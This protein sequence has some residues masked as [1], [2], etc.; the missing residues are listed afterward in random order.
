MKA[1]THDSVVGDA[2][3]EVYEL[4]AEK[5]AAKSRG[6]L[7]PHEVAFSPAPPHT[8]AD[9]SFRCFE[10]ARHWKT[11]PQEIAAAL[12]EDLEDDELVARAVPAGPYLNLELARGPVTRK[13]LRSVRAEGGDYGRSEKLA[14]ERVMMEYVSPNTN[15]PLHLGHLRNA[16]LGR[17][18]A[19]LIAAQGAEVIKT[20]IVNDRGIHIAKS[21]LAYERFAE[22]ETP[23][24]AGVKGDH[25]VGSLYVR[26]EKELQA[27][28]K[29][30]LAE[31]GID[32]KTLDDK[33]KKDVDER[34]NE[35]SKL[36]GGARD[37]LRRWEAGDE[38][39]RALWRRMNGWVY[40]GFAETYKLLGVDFDKHYYESEIF[41]GGRDII[42]DALERG[43]FKKAENGAVIAPLSE[44]G[45]LQDKVV[46][47]ADG[48]GLYI[49][50]DVNLATIKFKEFN[51]TRSLYCIGSEQDFYMKQLF[52]TLKLLG[53]PWADGLHHL[54]YGMVYLPE[55]K[56][57]S[58]EGKVVD[59]DDL[60]AGMAQLA[61]EAIRERDPDVPEGELERRAHA[62]GLAAMTFHFLLVGKD[63]EV[64]FDPKSSLA[65]E[66]KTGPYLQ[67][68]HA[69]VASIFR[70]AG[71]F[72][73]PA[74]IRLDEDVEWRIV[75]QLL[76][77]PLVVADAAE[78]YDPMRLANYLVELAQL[79]NSFY[80]D[81]PVLKSEE[82]VR[83]S[84]LALLDAFR[85]VLAN[86]LGLLSIEPLEEM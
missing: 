56:M 2:L 62:I 38:E 65:F 50:Q 49:T 64:H 21:M 70:K 69:R 14:G 61:Q 18:V 39:A 59:A 72:E 53:F 35:V 31:Q 66:G 11:K 27:E 84:R 54:S 71:D 8:G 52:A 5:V 29:A 1:L 26:F 43:I 75:F 40:D 19:N 34:F 32:P 17:A 6:A 51:L 30:W 33:Q 13:L 15:K 79:V 47:R 73:P 80:H 36:L 78:S 25:F 45:K 3:V 55:G 4:L 57:K 28:K 7:E 48:T 85:T 58:R 12:A 74:E 82:P 20:D 16:L 77:Y 67:Y 22:G 60:M 68:S 41:E 23:E 9:L 63:T 46:L 86:G 83:S 37:L 24:S 76:L 44:H 10:L 42:M 81:H